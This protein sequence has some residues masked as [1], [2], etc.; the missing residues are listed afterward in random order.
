MTDMRIVKV[1]IEGEFPESC[2]KCNLATIKYFYGGGLE[3]SCLATNMDITKSI[4]NDCRPDWCPLVK[5][6]EDK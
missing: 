3:G 4:E 5:E 2:R 6:S 1:V